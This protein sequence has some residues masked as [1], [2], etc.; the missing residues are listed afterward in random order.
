[1]LEQEMTRKEAKLTSVVQ[2][3]KEMMN[4]LVSLQHENVRLKAP[5]MIRD[6]QIQKIERKEKTMNES[7]VGRAKWS[8]MI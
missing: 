2:E 5:G 7:L 3:G 1:M 6:L 8:M 4:Q